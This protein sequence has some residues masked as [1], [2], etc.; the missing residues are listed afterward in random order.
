VSDLSWSRN[1]VPSQV[2][3]ANQEVNVK[4]LSLD[5]ERN[6]IALGYKQLQPRPWDNVE[7]KYPVGSILERKVVRIR[8]F[9]AFIEL[10]P[11]VDGLVHISQVAPTRIEKV[12]DVLTPGQDVRVKVLAVDPVAKRISLSI[13]EA[14]EDSV[15]DYHTDIPGESTAPSEEEVHQ[16]PVQTVTQPEDRPET[17]LELAMRKAREELMAKEQEVA[18]ETASENEAVTE[19][20][21]EAAEDSEEETEVV[22]E[23]AEVVDAE[24]K[25]ENE[26]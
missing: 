3:K 10:E 5:R 26:A 21:V 8:D 13:R 1:I 14:L 12:E 22:E 24:E 15:I 17:A 18:A 11:G 20:K 2:L 25:P 16:E 7:E 9:G 6:R 4:I 19:A 23:T